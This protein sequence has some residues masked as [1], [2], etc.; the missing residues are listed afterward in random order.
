VWP[1]LVRVGVGGPFC[2]AAHRP[3]ACSWA[4]GQGSWLGSPVPA[5]GRCRQALCSKRCGALPCPADRPGPAGRAYQDPTRPKPAAAASPVT[6]D[7]G[8]YR[9]AVACRASAE[10]G[11]LLVQLN[12]AC[13]S[14][15]AGSWGGPLA[16]WLLSGLCCEALCCEALCWVVGAGCE[17][18]SAVLVNAAPKWPVIC[19]GRP[20]RATRPQPWPHGPS[21]TGLAAAAGRR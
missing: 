3:R 9:P 12:T 4:G 2:R 20:S 5:P 8:A 21:A 10:H 11:R 14:G 6:T 1:K 7:S 13:F 19:N 16:R 18:R 15:L 17:T